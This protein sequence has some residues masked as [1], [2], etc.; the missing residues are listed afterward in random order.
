MFEMILDNVDIK[1]T[2]IRIAIPRHN[3][4]VERK[5]RQD[6]EKFYKHLKMKVKKHLKK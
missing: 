3:G 5:H 2:R 6:S 1:Y 4:K